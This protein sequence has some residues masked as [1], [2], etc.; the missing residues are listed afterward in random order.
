M[1]YILH[2]SSANLQNVFATKQRSS[3]FVFLFFFFFSLLQKSIASGKPDNLPATYFIT[4]NKLVQSDCNQSV[5]HPVLL[6]IP[7]RSSSPTP[8]RQRARTLI[9]RIHPFLFFGFLNCMNSFVS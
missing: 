8:F 4:D 7:E 3:W 5:D 1:H 6:P 9:A 2:P